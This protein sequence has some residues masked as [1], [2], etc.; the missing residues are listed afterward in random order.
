MGINIETPIVNMFK[1]RG[2]KLTVPIILMRSGGL[3]GV[4]IQADEY[5]AMLTNCIGVDAKIISGLDERTS[6]DSDD[7]PPPPTIIERLNFNHPDSLLLFGNEFTM[8]PET[9]GVKQ[10]S[11][12]EWCELFERHKN[13]I[14][15]DIDKIIS[16]IPHNTP[17]IVFNLLSLRHAH[18]AAAVALREIIE[19]YPNRAF[20][21]HAADPDAERP[22]KISRI[23]PFVL[24]YISANKMDEEYSGGPY[25]MDNLYHIVLN[26]KQHEN[27]LYKYMIK[28]DHVFEM[29]DFLEFESDT[30]VIPD[31][32][33]DGF[34]DYIS[35]KCIFA[36]NDHYQYSTVPIPDDAV[37]FLSPVRPV[38]RKRIKEAMLVAYH[39]GISRDKTVVFV[40]T[41]PDIDDRQYFMETVKF[42]NAMGVHYVHLG[43]SFSMQKLN[44]VYK[45]FSAL[46]T[47]GVVASA[48]GGWENALN[49]LAASC[50]PFF[51]SITLNSF[52]TL[53]EHMDIKTYG[54]D[55]SG[56]SNLFKTG[57]AERISGVDLSGIAYMQNLIEWID[58]TMDPKKREKIVVHNF[59]QAYK[60]LSQEA[61]AKRLIKSFQSVYDRH[62]PI[63]P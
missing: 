60:Y 36:E 27:F 54:M 8:G 57:L 6:Y 24:K 32:P 2:I 12:Q 19:K 3:D 28:A 48:A 59:N 52:K 58:E 34:I 5:Y 9:N 26:P 17:V 1:E 45:N 18:P 31:K 7:I 43:E 46:N 42:A 55:F 38:Y 22:E 29:P 14:R 15:N 61:A 21:S 11:E 4:A 16:E 50:I 63:L 37:Y 23:K 51:M 20:L 30:P 35:S 47:V 10:I 62:K 25:K 40:V 49:E 39:Y 44:Y 13:S 53:T 41:H 56:L 33:D